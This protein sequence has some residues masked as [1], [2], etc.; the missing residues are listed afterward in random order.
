MNRLGA[1]CAAGAAALAG[2]SLMWLPGLP[3]S[4]SAAAWTAPRVLSR[5]AEGVQD[6]HVAAA[7]G[8][9]AIVVWREVRPTGDRAMASVRVD[10]G[11]WR[12]ARDLSGRS[13]ATRVQA[14]MSAHG[15]VVA[16]A[17]RHRIMLARYRD[18]SGWTRA[19]SVTRG[20]LPNLQDLGVA[21]D[22]RGDISVVWTQ[23]SRTK[24]LAYA[25][26]KIARRPA[27]GHWGPP[28]RLT[29]PPRRRRVD[30]DSRLAVDARGDT[31]VAWSHQL[32][33]PQDPQS[34][35]LLVTVR[36][37]RSGHGWSRATVLG[38]TDSPRTTRLTMNSRGDTAL[39]WR[40]SAS[41]V[42]TAVR[43]IG[44]AWQTSELPLPVF[45][46]VKGDRLALDPAG[47]A[48]L[49]SWQTSPTSSSLTLVV[50]QRLA[51]GSWKERVIV[52]NPGDYAPNVAVESDGTTILVWHSQLADTLQ[53]IRQDPG[54]GWGPVETVSTEP[55]SRSVY[56]VATDAAAHIVVAWRDPQAGGLRVMVAS[57]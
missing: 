22:R 6:L 47:N 25:G 49:V 36:T 7:T 31:T 35:P 10:G 14:A 15:A 48:T 17:A 50:D 11:Q 8:G 42:S 5:P 51:T 53:A 40:L 24:T 12:T 52:G 43:S 57:G 18:S 33:D 20:E 38:G 19:Q 55:R 32:G 44:G 37:R 16:W 13:G 9:D 30:F 39:A 26:V 56:Q 41:H 45:W 3:A 46:N 1:I 28:V 21:M 29:G 27:G 4:A 34:G 2:A 23:A 54:G